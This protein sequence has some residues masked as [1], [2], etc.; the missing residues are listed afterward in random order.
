MS[1]R[2][3]PVYIVPLYTTI[4][5]RAGS[6]L[7]AGFYI[8][9]TKNYYFLILYMNKK[10]NKPIKLWLYLARL[11]YIRWS[12]EPNFWLKRK[13]ETIA[14][15]LLIIFIS[16]PTRSIFALKQHKKYKNVLFNKMKLKNRVGMFSGV[17][18]C[19]AFGWNPSKFYVRK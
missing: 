5:F 9:L 4:L 2:Q 13:F 8:Y 16:K 12:Y 7:D 6:K 11:W 3:P 18:V 15:F 1:R 19:M 10:L 17:C 14:I